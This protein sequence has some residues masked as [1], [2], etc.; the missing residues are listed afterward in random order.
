MQ[1]KDAGIVNPKNRL[2]KFWF[3]IVFINAI[4]NLLVN[5]YVL[6]FYV[7]SEAYAG[8]G[9][10]STLICGLDFLLATNLGYY[11]KMENFIADRKMITFKYIKGY[12]APDLISITPIL[13][14]VYANENYRGLCFILT[15]FQV[16]KLKRAL[17]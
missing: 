16:L 1:H 13:T 14:L 9:I 8:Y 6:A 10:F 4:V 5:P 7:E 11:D 12:M 15:L 3:L 17:E 2:V